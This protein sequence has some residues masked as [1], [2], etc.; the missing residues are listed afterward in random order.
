MIEVT[1]AIIKNKDK[2]LICQRPKGKKMADM[3]EFPGGKT[4][5]GET[6]E[7]CIIRECNEELDITI[8][9]DNIFADITKE[10][11]HI[12]FFICRIVE[13]TIK[14]KEHQDSRWVTKEE[15]SDYTFCPAD[16]KVI[17]MLQK[18][19]NR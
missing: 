2:I 3:W 17:E 8:S 10:D 5:V 1:A 12:T 7:Q 15:L 18:N 13:G 6:S 19:C 9:I 11:L 16:T 4:E 14:L